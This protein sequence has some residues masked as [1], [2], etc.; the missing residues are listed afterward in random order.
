[1]NRYL[2][3]TILSI[4]SGISIAQDEPASPQTTPEAPPTVEVAMSDDA[5]Q[6]SNFVVALINKNDRVRDPFGMAMDPANMRETVIANAY[7]ELE[8]TPTLTSS[9]LKTALEGLPITGIYPKGQ[10]IVIGARTF[11]PGN[12]FGMQLEELTIRLRFEGIR[13][14]EVYFKDMDT[15][16][17][18]S[19][20]FNPKPASFEPITKGSKPQLGEGIVPM[21]DLF[22]VN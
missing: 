8:E 10:M 11:K 6:R 5:L 19:V 18:S 1:M 16:E 4:W 14:T 20:T 15:Q 22:I 7:D 2:S 12:Q 17:T 13:G 3:L 9:S 21:N